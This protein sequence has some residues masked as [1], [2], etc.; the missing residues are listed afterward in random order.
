MT[1]VYIVNHDPWAG[2]RAATFY[3]ESRDAYKNLRSTAKDPFVIKVLSDGCQ[4][5]A[6][7]AQECQ[8]YGPEKGVDSGSPSAGSF[9]TS[10]LFAVNS[11][12]SACLV[13]TGLLKV[14]ATADLTVTSYVGRYVIFSRGSCEGRWAEISSYN[15][16]SRCASLSAPASGQWAD[17][18]EPCTPTAE[19]G[20][21]LASPQQRA[22]MAYPPMSCPRC[23]PS[24]K[25]L[26]TEKGNGFYLVRYTPSG[27]GSYSIFGSVSLSRVSRV[28][29]LHAPCV[30]V[31]RCLTLIGGGLCR[32]L[33]GGEGLTATYYSDPLEVGTSV[34]IGVGHPVSSRVHTGSIDWSATPTRR[35]PISSLTTT[36]GFGVRWAGF[37][38]ASHSQTYTFSVS[39]PEREG[40]SD[41]A[42]HTRSASHTHSASSV[43]HPSRIKLWVDNQ[44]IIDQWSS[45]THQSPTGKVHFDSHTLYDVSLLYKCPTNFSAASASSCQHTLGWKSGG[46]V[47]SSVVPPNALHQRIQMDSRLGELRVAGGFGCVSTTMASGSAL[48]LA[49]A[50]VHSSFTIT[51]RD[52]YGNPRDSVDPFFLQLIGAQN[53][54]LYG[55]VSASLT[56]LLGTSL[57]SYVAF[58]AKQYQLFVQQSGGDIK[59]SPFALTVLPDRACGSTST[60]SG[61]ALTA[62]SLSPALNSFSLQ[63]RD[64][65]GNLLSDEGVA[66]EGFLVRVVRTRS[67]NVQGAS[68]G[69]LPGFSGSTAL[70]DPGDIPTLHASLAF[71]DGEMKGTYSIPV[72]PSPAG[73]AHYIHSSWIQ[74]GGLHAT[75]Y[76][77]DE[78]AS[79]A[80]LPM[81]CRQCH[82]THKFPQ[83]VSSGG[84]STRPA[85]LDSALVGSASVCGS[86][87]CNLVIRWAGAIRACSSAADHSTCL[88]APSYRREFKWTIAPADRVKLWLDNKLIIDQWSSLSVSSP[89]AA[90]VFGH[91]DKVPFTHIEPTCMCMRA[92]AHSLS[93]SLSLSLSHTHTLSLSLSP[94]PP[95]CLP[96]SLLCVEEEYV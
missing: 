26:V 74:R 22:S 85:T 38:S 12:D 86:L 83:T 24:T 17:G 92:R 66:G 79:T 13:S 36:M 57:G 91:A 23:Q 55:G 16:S 28:L 11:T 31:D 75:Y 90:A 37:V 87:S 29:A 9:L 6:A 56:P 14:P 78:S 94:P 46:D 80:Q 3:I 72:I 96:A 40:A 68:H 25:A 61:S 35:W 18:L 30:F 21:Y 82:A 44:L 77:A 64:S 50:G 48:T 20:F 51:S 1:Q 76:S 7:N 45:L 42:S 49:T 34:N 33:S 27:R 8:P 69:G 32:A 10:N 62:A 39:M 2:M 81:P 5:P 47:T 54:P 53:S 43:E 67:P 73:Q 60:L 84:V 70:A 59:G 95:S 4:S 88:G 52:A 71:Q 89:S 63:A 15:T 65:F 93:L 41:S 58:E 19:T